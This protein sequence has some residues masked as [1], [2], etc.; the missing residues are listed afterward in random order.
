D[1]VYVP[2][3][4]KWADPSKN[5]KTYAREFLQ[6]EATGDLGSLLNIK[7]PM[8]AVDVTRNVTFAAVGILAAWFG[9]RLILAWTQ[10]AVS[11]EAASA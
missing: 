5:L 1:D 2:H 11:T 4:E 8:F 3:P 9:N 6:A 10:V 7:G